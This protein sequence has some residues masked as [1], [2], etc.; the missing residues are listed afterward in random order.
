VTGTVISTG[1][2]HTLAIEQDGSLWVREM[3][4]ANLAMEHKEIGIPH[5][6]EIFFNA[7]FF[8]QFLSPS[9]ECQDNLL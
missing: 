2:G 8:L 6:V 5:E 9:S 3:N 1:G 4:L 7:F